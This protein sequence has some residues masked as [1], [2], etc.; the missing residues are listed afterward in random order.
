MNKRLEKIAAYI[1]S[2]VG[3]IDVG[4]D[5]GYL[6]VALCQRGYEGNIIASDINE[7]PLELAKK[8]A[9]HAGVDD[10]IKFLLSDGLD[11]C[12]GDKIDTIVIAGMGGDTICG[13]LDRSE[14][15]MDSRYK[16]IFQPM[17]KA[18]ILRYWLVNNGF[19]ICDEALVQDCGTL[20]QVFTA[21]FDSE[22][23]LCDAE[24]FTGGKKQIENDPLFPVLLER[25]IK[26]F[27][28]ALASMHT[29][30]PEQRTPGKTQIMESILLQLKEMNGYDHG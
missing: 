18:E 1:Q 24:L 30:A 15:Y 13:I 26:R 12:D 5:H 21:R 29:A 3:I 14:W 27:E 11:D 8:N 20:Y 6:P 10:K 28:K 16:L 25:E 23:L 17:T 7:A 2:G 4:T 22:T 19:G 9:R